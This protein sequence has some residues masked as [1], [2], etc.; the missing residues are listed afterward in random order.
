MKQ[1]FNRGNQTIEIGP[2]G[3][4]VPKNL[5]PQP[6]QLGPPAG[7]PVGPPHTMHTPTSQSRHRMNPPMTPV[8][9]D[10]SQSPSIAP[11]PAWSPATSDISS[12]SSQSSL[13]PSFDKMAL[14]RGRGRPHKT[15]KPPTY[16]DY[17]MDG[18][19]AE[20]NLWVR[21]KS[22]E[23]W[24]YNKLMSTS[25]QSYREAENLRAS[26]FYYEKRKGQ[27][28]KTAAVGK[29]PETL[30]EEQ[31]VSD[32]AEVEKAKKKDAAMEKSRLRYVH[33][34]YKLHK[35]RKIFTKNCKSKNVIVNFI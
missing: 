12:T 19:K 11:S 23:Q 20:Q 8:T 1:F 15:L 18:T 14:G 35:I 7:M 4:L 31:D 29:A 30:E 5:F 17:P 10:I 13:T 3:H 22:A 16:D 25:A 6:Q 21:R 28:K 32:A 34:K 2:E 24:R 27:G 9:P 33:D 26:K